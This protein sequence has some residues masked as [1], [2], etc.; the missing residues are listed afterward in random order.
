MVVICCILFKTCI[1]TQSI[2]SSILALEKNIIDA[3]VLLHLAMS[4][5][6]N[7]Y[8]SSAT[9]SVEVEKAESQAR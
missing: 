7:Q 3:E 9:I 1:H 6:S 4:E 2:N 8:I 5:T